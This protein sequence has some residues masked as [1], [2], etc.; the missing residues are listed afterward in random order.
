MREMLKQ[1]CG[2]CRLI[3]GMV[4]W[5]SG[6]F[7]SFSGEGLA[8]VP[9]PTTVPALLAAYLLLWMGALATNFGL[10]QLIRPAHRYFR[11]L[12]YLLLGLSA[13]GWSVFAGSALLHLF[14]AEVP[15]WP[16]LHEGWTIAALGT[17][18]SWMLMGTWLI[19]RQ[20]WFAGASLLAISGWLLYSCL[21][22]GVNM[23]PVLFYT[24]AG[25]LSLYPLLHQ[26]EAE[27]NAPLAPQ[28]QY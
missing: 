15:T 2:E 18:T 21:H 20:Q 1:Y 5:W 3:L 24:L 22:L 8:D 14:Q 7:L 16:A 9:I 4:C 10:F 23:P 27:P 11:T 25:L 6:A 26:K 19:S 28:E 17:L 13:F 12:F